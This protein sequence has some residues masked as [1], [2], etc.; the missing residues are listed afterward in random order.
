MAYIESNMNPNLA[1]SLPRKAFL[2]IAEHCR[3]HVTDFREIYDSLMN[4]AIKGVIT[5]RS[6]EK[7]TVT[8]H[9]NVMIVE[10]GINSVTF[11][12]YDDENK[13]IEKL[14]YDMNELIIKD[15]DYIDKITYENLIKDFQ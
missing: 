7:Y 14:F 11:N 1:I 4:K 5:G 15:Q 10:W 3:Q 8:I 9:A 6:G 12:D 2:F 13:T